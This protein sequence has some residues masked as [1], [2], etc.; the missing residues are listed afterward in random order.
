MQ[1]KK[2]K[3]KIRKHKKITPVKAILNINNEPSN[4]KANMKVRRKV[5]TTC[6]NTIIKLNGIQMM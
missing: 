5:V 3:L 4:Y 6:I 1:K 2:S